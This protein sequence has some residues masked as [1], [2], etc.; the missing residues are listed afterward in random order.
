M[1]KKSQTDDKIRE[2][3]KM[4]K[5]HMEFG[6]AILNHEFMINQESLSTCFNLTKNRIAYKM[7]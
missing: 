3:R 4:F 7:G 6:Q 1:T 2:V 5:G